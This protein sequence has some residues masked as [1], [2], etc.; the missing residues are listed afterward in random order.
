MDPGIDGLET[1]RQ[2]VALHPA[3]RS[4]IASGYAETDKV[5]NA[6]HFGAGEYLKKPY[7][8]ESLGKAV[9]NALADTKREENGREGIPPDWSSA[10]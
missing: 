2:I 7:M 8:I 1:W 9:K 5:K 10:S 4:I 3:Q 6:Q